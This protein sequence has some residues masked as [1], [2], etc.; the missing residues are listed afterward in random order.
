[1]FDRVFIFIHIFDWHHKMNTPWKIPP[2][3]SWD[4]CGMN[5]YFMNGKRLLYVAMSK[6]NIL[7]KHEGADNLAL[8]NHLVNKA[9]E[10]ENKDLSFVYCSS[11]GGAFQ[12][13][14]GTGFSHCADHKGIK[15][16]D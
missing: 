16:H 7:I 2:L 8:W 13:E 1:M 14:Q 10:I 12:L 9:K 3:D 15:K 4:I 6:N 11:C 5:H